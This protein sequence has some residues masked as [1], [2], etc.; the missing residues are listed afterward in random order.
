MLDRFKPSPGER[1]LRSHSNGKFRDAVP[2]YAHG[3]DYE[4]YLKMGFKHLKISMPHG[5]GSGR[6]GMKKN[7]E[8]VK[9]FREMLGPDGMLMA[10]VWMGWTESYAIRMVEMLAPYKIHWLE[11]ILP[12]YEYAGSARLR[13]KIKPMLLNSGEHEYGRY[14][15]RLMME[16]RSADVWNPDLAWAG[17]V[18]EVRRIAA[19][20]SAYDIP[21]V[22][23]TGAKE[24]DIHVT[25]AINSPFAEMYGPIP[26]KQFE[27]ERFLTK[28]P[29]G[30]YTRPPDTPGFG[31]DFVVI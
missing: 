13:E 17:G 6:E 1:S 19:M 10:D 24:S 8:V 27:E 18:T 25:A 28:G 2:C 20:A 21:V 29:E 16:H 14:G 5:P 7:V 3:P 23:H 31:W 15:F 12:P 9:R 22:M 4:A 26:T 11:E 30:V